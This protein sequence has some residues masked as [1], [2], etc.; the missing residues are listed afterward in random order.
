MRASLA[1]TEAMRK[2]QGQKNP[3]KKR[4]SKTCWLAG[5][6]ATVDFGA[7]SGAWTYGYCFRRGLLDVV[8]E[9]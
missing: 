3:R 6:D 8:R 1:D 7:G 2:K 4:E 9:W 5:V